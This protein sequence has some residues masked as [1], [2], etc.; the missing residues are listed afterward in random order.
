MQWE[1]RTKDSDIG[2]LAFYEGVMN[3]I[4]VTSVRLTVC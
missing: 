2:L 4:F 3:K 1:K